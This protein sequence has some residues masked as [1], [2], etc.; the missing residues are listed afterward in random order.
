MTTPITYP[1]L[2]PQPFA[3]TGTK[4]TIPVASVTPLASLVDGFPPVTMQPIS[5]GGVPPSGADMNGILYWV[6]QF[7]AW[8]NGGGRFKFDSAF[9]TAIGG[10]PVGAV[11]M[12]N[13]NVSEVICTSASNTN[14][15]NSVMTGWA[16]YAGADGG[17]GEYVADTGVVNAYVATVSP[18][19]SSYKNGYAV[20][21]RALHTNTTSSTINTGGGVV[22][23]LTSG[24]A[25]L[26][27]GMIQAGSIYQAVYDSG[28]SAFKLTGAPPRIGTGVDQSVTPNTITIN[29]S[30]NGLLPVIGS[31]LVFQVGNQ[32]L[33]SAVTMQVAGFPSASLVRSDLANLAAYDLGTLGYYAAVFVGQVVPLG[34]AL[35]QLITQVPS[36]AVKTAFATQHSL[37]VPSQR[38]NNHNYT[39]TTGKPMYVCVTGEASGAVQW[40]SL[41]SAPATLVPGTTNV[42]AGNGIGGAGSEGGGV[43]ISAGGFIPAGWQ[44]QFQW[45]IGTIRTWMET[46]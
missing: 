42:I 9:S 13:D 44:Y 1:P 11:L 20:I 34:P 15:P 14:D 18:P 46:Y 26:T 33:T 17:R 35:W 30:P 38:T 19:I 37:S 28:V 21:F 16:P 31:V 8:V 2:L 10:Y 12:L 29:N 5:A 41:Y 32:N 39:N 36:Q 25:A 45:S 7:Q 24:G 40:I 43:W 23:L 3:T 22:N 27:A 6:T 4:N